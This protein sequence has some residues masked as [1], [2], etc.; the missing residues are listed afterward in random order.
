MGMQRNYWAWLAS[1]AAWLAVQTALEEYDGQM[2]RFDELGGYCW[3]D[4]KGDEQQV[5]LAVMR[6][7]FELVAR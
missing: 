3:V 7:L 5:Q 6:P 1:R 4:E 2:P